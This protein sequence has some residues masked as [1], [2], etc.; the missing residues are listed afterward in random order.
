MD[1]PKIPKFIGIRD[2]KYVYVNYYEQ[3]P[4]YEFLHDLERDP[5]QLGNLANRPEY[6][7]LLKRLRSQCDSTEKTLKS[8]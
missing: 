2:Q 8:E 5:E 6:E 4:P 3:E 7:K 1:H